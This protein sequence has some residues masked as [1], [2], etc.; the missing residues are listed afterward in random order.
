ML[1]LLFYVL[2]VLVFFIGYIYFYNKLKKSKKILKTKIPDVIKLSKRK[3]L[4]SP[5][6]QL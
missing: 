6:R 3:Q 5:R 4:G 1:E 2:L